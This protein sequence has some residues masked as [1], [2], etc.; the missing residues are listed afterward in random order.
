MWKGEPWTPPTLQ[1]CLKS[2]I[3]NAELAARDEAGFRGMYTHL[4]PGPECAETRM[5]ISRAVNEQRHWRELAA[6]HRAE[7]ART[8]PDPRLPREADEPEGLPF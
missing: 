6:W 1:E 5:K 7:I 8:A 4:Q 2:C 3:D